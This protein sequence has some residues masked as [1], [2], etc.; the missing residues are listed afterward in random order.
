M[1]KYKP[2]HARLQYIDRMIREKRYPS[3]A[4]LAEGWEVSERTIQRDLDYL[5]YELDAPLPIR[6]NIA[7]STTPRSSTS[8][9]PSTCAKATCSQS[10]WL[11]C[12]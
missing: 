8:C 2:Q 10:I 12:Y 1:A 9:R 11:R 6:P 3:C 5:R 4:D 7:A